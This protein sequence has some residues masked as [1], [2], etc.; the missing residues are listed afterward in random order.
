MKTTVIFQETIEIRNTLK[1]KIDFKENPIDT[2]LLPV[3]PFR[4]TNKIKFIILGQDPTVKN[5]KSRQTIEYTLNLDKAGSLKAYINQICSSLGISFENIYATNVFKYFYTYPPERTMHVLHAHLPSNLELLKEELA[6][7]PK[8]PVIVLGLPVLQLLAGEKAQ[9]RE[10]WS[11]N[12]KTRKCDGKFTFCPAKD[13][14][15]DRDIYPFPHQPS[16]RKD[17]YKNNLQN[18]INYMKENT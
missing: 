5:E 15:L 6:A 16:I 14:K 9:V 1:S 17:F 12:S 7:Y 4:I 2:N 10:F 8:V 18:Y 11:Y 3:L 13:N